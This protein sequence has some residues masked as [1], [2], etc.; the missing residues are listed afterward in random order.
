MDP[1]DISVPQFI[2]IL[3]NLDGWLDKAVAHAKTKSFDPTV[4]LNMRLAPDQYP[5]VRQV[6]GACDA[7]KFGAARLAGTDPPSH[8]DTET[9]MDEIRAR[10]ATC[11]AYLE[12]FK[13]SDFNG[14]RDRRISLPWM[15]GKWM[16]PEDY[17]VQMSIPNFFFHAT[18][19]YAILRHAGVDVGKRDYLGPIAFND[20]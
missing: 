3:R 4:L 11:L 13:P 15:S 18:H 8:P 20:G 6:Q 1:Y 7:A 16:R 19:A 12:G 2:R 9:T 10:I 5:L 14:W 17:L